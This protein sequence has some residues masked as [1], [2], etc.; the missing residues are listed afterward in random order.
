MN[1]E[2][3]A[4]GVAGLLFC[5]RRDIHHGERESPARPCLSDESGEKPRARYAYACG[6]YMHSSA[7]KRVLAA[8]YSNFR[9]LS[10]TRSAESVDKAMADVAPTGARAAARSS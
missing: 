5:P 10:E 4:T 2:F 6:T 7:C 8:Q 9:K 1:V 3:Q